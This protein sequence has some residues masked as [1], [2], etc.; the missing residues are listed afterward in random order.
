MEI[1]QD[2]TRF[3]LCVIS[4]LIINTGIISGTVTYVITPIAN[5]CN[6]TPANLVVTVLPT[7]FVS[8]A[9]SPLNPRIFVATIT[10]TLTITSNIAGATFSAG[11][12]R[13]RIGNLTG[14]SANE[15]GDI[16]DANI[17]NS[18]IVVPVTYTITPNL[19]IMWLR[20]KSEC[21]LLPMCALL[22]IFVTT[23][24]S[25][26]PRLQILGGATFSWTASAS[27]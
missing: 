12:L 1:S 3:F 25:H 19:P 22:M 14:F 26:S 13:P 10:A 17:L 8:V 6:G 27:N 7:E 21:Q 11:L 24:Q 18:R 2:L 20:F 4:V 5:G 23:K 16:N 9:N 15:T